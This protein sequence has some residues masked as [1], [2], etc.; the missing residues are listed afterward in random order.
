MLSQSY[1]IHEKSNV[2]PIKKQPTSI[3]EFT[4]KEN[5]FDPLQNSPPN[6]FMLKL[7]IRMNQ[8]NTNYIKDESRNS[9]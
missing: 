5:L 1:I 2:I 8:F 4:L 3:K 7:Y 6:E 9:E